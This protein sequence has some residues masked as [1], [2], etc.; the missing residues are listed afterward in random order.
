MKTAF[1]IAAA[2]MVAVA[3]A[4]L[5]LPL[6]RQGRKSGRSRGVFALTLAIALVVPLGTGALYLL[7]GTPAALNGV[8]A[9]AAA[10]ASLQQ[11]LV[12]LR[13]HLQ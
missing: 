4:V 8:S 6:V 13:E 9:Q 11:A 5:L 12:E 10:P 3:L 1:L 7:V 2:V